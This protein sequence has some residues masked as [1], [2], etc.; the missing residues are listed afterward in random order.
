MTRK[1]DP[2]TTNAESTALAA[3]GAGKDRA[4]M[5]G[6]HRNDVQAAAGAGVPCIF[7]GWGYGPLAMA[8]G[9]PV[10]ATPHDLPRMIEA[11]LA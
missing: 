3:A 4:V 7:A 6:D 1:N 11:L 8:D 5:I 10:A 2:L 9:A